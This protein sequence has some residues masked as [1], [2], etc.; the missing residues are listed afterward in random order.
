MPSFG[1]DSEKQLST[2]HPDIQRVFR[3]VVQYWDCTILEGKRSEAQQRLNVA[4]GASKTMDSKHVY[5]LGSPS[6]GVDAAPYPIKWKDYLRF[7]AFAG[8]VIGTATAMGV[9][10]RWGGDW[11]NDRDFSEETFRDLVH[12]ELAN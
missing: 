1:S 12:F 7:Y 2:C 10:L 5:P 9:S 6:L 3:K 8:F 11:D 4:S